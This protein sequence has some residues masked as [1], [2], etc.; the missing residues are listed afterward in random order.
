MRHA[1]DL[2][3]E[4]GVSLNLNLFNTAP[5]G[6]DTPG[7][8]TGAAAGVPQTS[9]GTVACPSC[10]GYVT[11]TQAPSGW[12]SCLYC[13]KQLRI[14]VWPVAPQKTNSESAMP[15]HATC[16]FHPE[17]AF[18]ACCQR[19]GR[20]LCALCDFQL[21]AEHVCPTC[22]ERGRA[23]TGRDGG[24][25]EWRHRDVLYDSIAITLGWG[26]ILVWPLIIA[27][28]PATIVLHVKFRK[29]PRAYLIPRSAWRFW[30][31]YAGFIWLPLLIAGS[32]FMA[33]MAGRH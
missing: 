4:L 5:S 1:C 27:A 32:I 10:G 14:Q 26:W 31:A 19:C 24:T 20:F 33:R 6:S 17:K 7:F 25:A 9:P 30:A 13:A 12:Q 29:A 21:G 3:T 15:E 16:F 22:F 18:E 23:D 28:L 2:Q 8:S 11:P